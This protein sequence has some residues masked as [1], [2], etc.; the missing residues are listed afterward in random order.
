MQKLL[1]IIVQQLPLDKNNDLIFDVDEARDIHENAVT[2]L[3]NAIGV[4]VLTTFTDVKSIDISDKSTTTS[5]DDLQKIERSLYNA[6]GTPQSIF[7]S[8]GNIALTNSILNDETLCKGLLLQFASFYDVICKKRKGNSKKYRFRFYMLETTQY[9]YKELAKLYKEQ[10]QI[11]NSKMLPQIALGQ[12]QSFILN[13][14]H[15]ENE[16]LKLYEIMIPPLMSST[17]SGETILNAKNGLDKTG[18]STSKNSQNSMETKTNGRPEKPDSEKSDK[19]IAN[20]ESL[21]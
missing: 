4:D 15:F 19:T 13:S 9:N 11:G 3:Q 14:C 5:A 21:G 12:S 7:N 1:K 10:T 17:I 18:N 2:M 16:I 20:L 8:T 6:F